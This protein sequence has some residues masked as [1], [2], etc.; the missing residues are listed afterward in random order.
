M[1]N[2]SLPLG[3]TNPALVARNE[4]LKTKVP[5]PYEGYINKGLNVDALMGFDKFARAALETYRDGSY[6]STPTNNWR[7]V[8]DF[9]SEKNFTMLQNFIEEKTGYPVHAQSLWETMLFVFYQIKP[10]SDAMDQ[11][12]ERTDDETTRSYVNEMNEIVVSRMTTETMAAQKHRKVFMQR[13]G[14]VRSYP[15]TPIDTRTRYVG[16][17][18]LFDYMLR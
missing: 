9:F 1:Y 5:G 4:S 2:R 10:R 17:S 16:S 18:Y 6:L 13:R 15:D 7:E 8:R 11:R 3:H 12:K 14:D